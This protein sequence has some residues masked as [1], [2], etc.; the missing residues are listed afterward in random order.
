MQF[1]PA[2]SDRFFKDTIVSVFKTDF[3]KTLFLRNDLYF[4]T[5]KDLQ[6]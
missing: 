5:K 4:F 2:I 6:K 3:N 1:I